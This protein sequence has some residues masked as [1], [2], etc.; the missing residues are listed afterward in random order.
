[1]LKIYMLKLLREFSPVK[2][3]TDRQ[4]I[5]QTNCTS[6]KVLKRIPFLYFA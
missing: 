4:R 3:D 1:M 5:V 6:A 2:E